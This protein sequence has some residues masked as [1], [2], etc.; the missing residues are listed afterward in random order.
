MYHLKF[1]WKQMRRER[2]TLQ[3]NPKAGSCPTSNPHRM[4]SR[5]VS[6]KHFHFATQTLNV[7]SRPNE[8]YFLTYVFSLLSGKNE[9]DPSLGLQPC[10]KLAVLLLPALCAHHPH[11]STVCF[12]VTA[13]GSPDLTSGECDL[14]V[15]ED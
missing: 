10:E 11:H 15:V 4:V 13:G 9:K 7:L 2:G 6:N 12:T 8:N 5:I 1:E 14:F 3:R